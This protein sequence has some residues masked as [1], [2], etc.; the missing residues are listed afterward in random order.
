MYLIND[1]ASDWEDGKHEGR[2]VKK[3]KPEF[4]LHSQKDGNRASEFVAS[5]I[6][7]EPVWIHRKVRNRSGD[8]WR[9]GPDFLTAGMA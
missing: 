2:T 1:L 5:V 9:T 6:A 7:L 8:G 4:H 3:S